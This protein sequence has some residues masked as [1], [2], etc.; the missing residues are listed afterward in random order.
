M[1][2]Q[3]QVQYLLVENFLLGAPNI[4]FLPF[5]CLIIGRDDSLKSPTCVDFVNNC[6][7]LT[8]MALRGF[9]LPDYKIRILLKVHS[10]KK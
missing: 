2:L 3:K 6:P 5:F 9:K 8:S 10:L 7:N 1:S 4:F